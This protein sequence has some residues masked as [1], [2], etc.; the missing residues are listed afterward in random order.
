MRKLSGQG[1]QIFDV[2]PH[3]TLNDL[4]HSIRESDPIG[5][6]DISM[7]LVHGDFVLRNDAGD[8]DEKT[9]QELGIVD[10][11]TLALVKHKL[12]TVVTAS[13]DGTAKL[14]ST[15]S[16]KCTQT[17]SGRVGG[18]MSAVFSGDGMCGSDS[19][20][21]WHSK[22]LEHSESKMHTDVLWPCRRC[23]VSCVLWRWICSLDSCKQ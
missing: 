13:G 22:T 18:V 16:G 14:W 9:L 12:C 23:E 6:H 15:A 8:Y 7:S 2:Y 17:F 10:G 21:R 4:K 20:S 5:F 19:F 1:P 3:S 11:S